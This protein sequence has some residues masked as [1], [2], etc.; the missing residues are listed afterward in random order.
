MPRLHS[1]RMQKTFYRCTFIEVMKKILSWPVATR[2]RRWLFAYIPLLLLT[3]VFVCDL[4]IGNNAKGRMYN[5][6]ADVPEN[7][8]ALV[9]GTSPRSHGTVNLYY[10]YRMQAAADLWKSGKVDY[11]I[12][13]GDN[14]RVNYDEATYMKKTLN[15]LGIPD[16]VI[17]LDYAGFRTLD[18]VVR[19]YW[20]FGQKNIVI[21]SQPFHNERA[22][23]I[24]DHFG[25]NA[26]A[27]NA[28]DV[29]DKYGWKTSLREYLARVNAVLDLFVFQT[30]P[31]FPGPPEPIH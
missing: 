1:G 17:T 19:A 26:C 29:P 4:W 5:R 18:S 3:F 21:V 10:M 7:S 16:S 20:V 30:T 24:A 31:K 8:A 6:I 13:S 22:I 14:S 11:I 28:K 27:Y 25:I 12:V 2:F 15:K 9:L 23:F